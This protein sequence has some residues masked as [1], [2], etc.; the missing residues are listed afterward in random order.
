MKSFCT[1]VSLPLRRLLFSGLDVGNSGLGT[2]DSADARAVEAAREAKDRFHEQMP[3]SVR[4]QLNEE[5]YCVAPFGWNE[6]VLGLLLGSGQFS[7]AFE[8]RSFRLA[9][10]PDLSAEEIERRVCMKKGAK[11]GRTKQARYALK[12][13]RRHRLET[14]RGRIEY[15][16]AVE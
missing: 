15:V 16:Q 9:D 11:H 13:V 6:C 8:V 14:R 2:A 1:R 3:D 7:D 5:Q 12:R 4:T 10:D